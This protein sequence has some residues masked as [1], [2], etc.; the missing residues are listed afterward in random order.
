MLYIVKRLYDSYY[1]SSLEDMNK[2]IEFIFTP[3]KSD[4]CMKRSCR[5]L[6]TFFTPRYNLDFKIQ[7]CKEIDGI[8]IVT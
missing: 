2:R 6:D 3:L 8:I 5:V 7:G 1:L 4:A